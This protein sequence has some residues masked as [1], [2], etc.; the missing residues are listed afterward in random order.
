MKSRIINLIISSFISIFT[1]FSLHTSFNGDVYGKITDNIISDFSLFSVA[2]FFILWTAIYWIIKSFHPYIVVFF[3][4]LNKTSVSGKKLA[5]RNLHFWLAIMFIV[6]SLYVLSYLPGGIFHDTFS[7]MH[8][9]KNNIYFSG[10][11]PFLAILIKVFFKIS[12]YFHFDYTFAMVLF[13]IFQMFCLYCVVSIVLLWLYKK[14]IHRIIFI[15]VSLYFVLFPLIPLYGISIWKDTWF[16]YFF[17]LWFISYIEIWIRAKN[18][19]FSYLYSIWFILSGLLM[20]LFRIGAIY[21]LIIAILIVM[22]RIILLQYKIVIHLFVAA[23]PILLFYF[24]NNLFVSSSVA[25]LSQLP[26]YNLILQQLAYTVLSGV[27]IKTE[28]WQI[29]NQIFNIDVLFDSYSPCYFDTLVIG[30]CWDNQYCS[31]HKFDVFITWLSL[32]IDNPLLYIKSFLLN[33]LGFWD[34]FY[35]THNSYVQTDI[36][37]TSFYA[38]QFNIQQVDIFY[39]VFGISLRPILKPI[40]HLSPALFCWPYLLSMAYVMKQHKVFSGLIFA[41]QLL[42]WL[43]YLFDTYI[44]FSLRYVSCNMFTLPFIILVPLLFMNENKNDKYS[45]KLNIS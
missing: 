36:S 32:G 27:Y 16:C 1:V 44:A 17:T 19:N 3:E 34:I 4:K 5:Y 8:E 18:N 22:F 41:P 14:N 37:S 24:I 20:C 31:S 15:S 11:P 2:L 13:S 28:S 21:I 30:D 43:E 9:A 39:T 26:L 7:S 25:G 38:E 10:N 6:Y 23:A 33:S 40:L 42:V 12:S 35:G 29:I 45:N